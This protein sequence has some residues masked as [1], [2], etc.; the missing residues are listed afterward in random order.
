MGR[1]T[2]FSVEDE[3]AES[4]RMAIEVVVSLEDGQRRLA[5][6]AT[7]DALKV[8][9]DWVPG[10]RVRYHVG[11]IAIEELSPEMIG[12]VLKHLDERGELLPATRPIDTA[13]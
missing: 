10:T 11:L 4:G 1:M 13:T 6:F 8:F 7:P 2:R 3:L 5:H 12:A 9:G